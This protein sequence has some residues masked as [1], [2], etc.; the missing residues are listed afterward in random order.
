M[1][2]I[3]SYSILIIIDKCKKI[4]D[5]GK[6]SFNKTLKFLIENTTY[7]KIMVITR[8][9]EDILDEYSFKIPIEI[10]DLTRL[11]AAKLLLMAAG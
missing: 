10:T 2:I 11:N 5:E 8:Q 4:L 7:A 6:L 1:D 9:K 3:K